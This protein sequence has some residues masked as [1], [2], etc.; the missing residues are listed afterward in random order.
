MP[1]LTPVLALLA[2]WSSTAAAIPAA[3]AAPPPRV[4]V[5]FVL[6][7]TGSMGGLIEGAKRRIWSIARRIGEG[8]PRPELRIALVGYR[9]KGD[10]YV[11]RVHDLTG[12]MDTVY[13]NLMAF[14]AEGGGDTPEHVSAALSDAVHRVSWSDGRA[15]RIIFLV[16]D[17]PPH[18]DYQDGFD[19]RRHA[20]EARQRG[21]VIETIECGNDPQTAQV[22]QEI[23]GLAEGHFA[24]IDQDGG[25]T[26]Q[27]TPVD[28]E[29]AKLNSELGS[30]VVAGGSAGDR[31]EAAAKVASRAAMAPAAAMEAAGYFA[32]A[33]KLVETDMV[34]MPEAE[35]KRQLDEL[36]KS[37][38]APPASLA[39]KTDAEALAYLKQ[40]KERRAQ[41]QS[42]ILELQKQ[43]DAYL[44]KN[45]A[46]DSFD[47][48]VVDSFK[49][50]AAG[51]G[52]RY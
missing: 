16:G 36:K 49:Q 24:R 39:G 46:K 27:V 20:R 33:D 11:T 18:V 12:D 30:T 19:Y 15:L 28:A 2:S 22:W 3:V 17:A 26:A 8:Q 31:R 35:Q 43:R 23:A 42:R 47:Q 1:R 5:A 13:A 40:Q 52:I 10:E 7:T 14:R 41:L 45:Q 44:A 48:Q 37:P 50:R 51:Y 21:I 38:V 32:R 4:E 29:L 34:D 25:M 9:D 6:D